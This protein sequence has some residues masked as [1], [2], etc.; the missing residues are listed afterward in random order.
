L[1]PRFAPHVRWVAWLDLIVTGAFV[2]PSIATG[3]IALL[4]DLELSFFGPGRVTALPTAPWS[5]FI[6]LMGLLGVVWAIARLI[7]EDDRLC[8]IDAVARMFVAGLI[9]FGLIAMNLPW[10]FFAFI[11]TELVGTIAT[12][13]LWRRDERLTV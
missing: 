1:T 9:I 4:L 12:L 2:L 8:L 3:V 11:L 6:S 10:I 5:I 13:I 7:V